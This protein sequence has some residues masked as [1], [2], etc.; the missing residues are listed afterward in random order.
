MG[1]LRILNQQGDIRVEWDPADPESTAHA[2]AE[3]D[4]L[5]KD[6]YKFYDVAETRGKQVTRWSK[7]AGTLLAAPGAKSAADKDKGTRRR[8]MGGGPNSRALVLR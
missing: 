7:N 2:K 1:A 6:G 5:K 3:Y 4:Q 8:A